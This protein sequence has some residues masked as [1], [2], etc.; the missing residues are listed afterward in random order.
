MIKMCCWQCWHTYMCCWHIFLF[1]IHVLNLY[2]CC[3]HCWHTFSH[4]SWGLSKTTLI[5]IYRSLIGS[6]I[7]YAS[8]TSSRLSKK[9]T[10]TLQALQNNAIRIIY[11]HAYDAHAHT[12]DLCSQSG[13]PRVEERSVELTGIYLSGA[14]ES[15]NGLIQQLLQSFST[16]LLKT[17]LS[18][19][20]SKFGQYVLK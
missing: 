16:R 1:A 5:S 2:M 18:Q 11:K 7:D 12:V 15:S 10:K 4:K 20:S 3:W 13:L 8:L 9:T 17:P 14:L 6:V 19:F